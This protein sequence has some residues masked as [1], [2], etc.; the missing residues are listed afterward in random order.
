MMRNT[1][2]GRHK[3]WKR[4]ALL[5][6]DDSLQNIFKTKIEGYRV[7]DKLFSG[8]DPSIKQSIKVIPVTITRGHK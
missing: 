7:K 5:W 1:T 3:S 6:P 2:D 8:C 4:W